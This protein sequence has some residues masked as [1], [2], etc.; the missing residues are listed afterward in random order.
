[1]MDFW[2]QASCPKYTDLFDEEDDSL[3]NA[4]QTIF[5]MTERA[6]SIGI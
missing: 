4:I 6:W 2:V 1:M 3:S 5:P